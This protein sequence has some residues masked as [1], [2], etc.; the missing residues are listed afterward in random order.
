MAAM[1]ATTAWKW[2]ALTGDLNVGWIA[3]NQRGISVA[4]PMANSDRVAAVALELAF[5]TQLLRMA[6][7]TSRPPSVPSTSVAIPPQ[8][9]PSLAARKSVIRSG[10][11]YTVA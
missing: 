6:K 1:I 8:G 5:A 7:I 4:R 10:P 11:K 3:A 9:S 2:I